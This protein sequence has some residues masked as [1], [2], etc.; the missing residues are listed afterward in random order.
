MRK[1]TT[2]RWARWIL[3]ALVVLWSLFPVYW[4]LN[5]GLM[6]NL[7]AMSTPSHWFPSPLNLSNYRQLLGIHLSAANPADL[8]PSFGRSALNTLVECGVSTI[9]TVVLA[10][11]SSYAFAR[12]EFRLKNVFFYGILFTLMLPAYATLIPLYRIMSQLGLVNTYTGIVLVYVSGFLPLA[13]WILYTNFASIPRALEEAAFIDA[14]TPFG[15]LTRIILPLAKPGITAAAII[16]FLTA[17]GQFI[18]PL[19]LSS[20]IS[21]SPLTIFIVNLQG[22]HTSSFSLIN[23]TGVLTILVPGLIVVFLNRYIVSGILAGAVK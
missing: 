21:T 14:A 5:T 16:A 20:D 9:V 6:S 7:S 17:W 19:V 10:T 1:H 11:I 18:F 3:V 2:F 4:A 23:A 22:N 13:M 15:A 12:M 8:W